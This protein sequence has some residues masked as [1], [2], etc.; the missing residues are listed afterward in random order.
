MRTRRLLLLVGLFVLLTAVAEAERKRD[1]L[2]PVE[3]DQLRDTA[4]E[5]D[6]RIKLYVKFARARLASLD[7]KR[8]DPKVADRGQ[9][10]HDGLE[11]FLAVY[12]E[13]NDNIDMYVDRK[14]DIRK[15]LKVVIEADTEFQ[16]KLRALDSAAG[17]SPEEKKE[18]QFV[19]SN[20][21]ETL[22]SSADDHRKLMEEQEE[23]AKHKKKAKAQ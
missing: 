3:I 6:L 16:A 15:P 9:A 5:P 23:A 10:T 21:I 22:D 12:D 2:T 14:E 1:P 11:D 17:T 18:Y 19:L 8:N 4:M 13:L 20:I 7:A